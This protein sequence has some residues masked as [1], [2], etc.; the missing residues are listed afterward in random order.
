MKLKWEVLGRISV[1]GGII[2]I[3]D[4]CYDVRLDSF[5][6]AMAQS[7]TA[8]IPHEGRL[9]PAGKDRDFAAA[10]VMQSGL[11]DGVYTVE[12]KRDPTFHNAIKEMRIKFF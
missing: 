11:G 4:P 1:D 12:I 5:D 8:V 9:E 6:E 2:Q 7:D 3:G 10:I